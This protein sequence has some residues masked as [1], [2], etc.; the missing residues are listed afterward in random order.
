MF[1][2]GGDPFQHMHGGGGGRGRGGQAADNEALYTALGLSK[3]AGEDEIK[4]AY[5]KLAVKHHPDKGGDP[6]KVLFLNVQQN[7]NYEHFLS[8]V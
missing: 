2:G 4:R 7:E 8:L 3:S 5:K 1:F 6:E